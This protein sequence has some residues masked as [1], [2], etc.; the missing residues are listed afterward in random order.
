MTQCSFLKR[1]KYAAVSAS[2]ALGPIAVWFIRNYLINKTLTGSRNSSGLPVIWNVWRCMST[3]SDW[4]I[5]NM[6][7]SDLMKFPVLMNI[8]SGMVIMLMFFRLKQINTSQYSAKRLLAAYG[9]IAIWFV[10]LL[11]NLALHFVPHFVPPF[12]N[13]P[14]SVNSA[15]GITIIALFFWLRAGHTAPPFAKELLATYIYIFLYVAFLIRAASTTGFDQINTRLL[16]PVYVFLVYAILAAGDRLAAQVCRKQ[17]KYVWAVFTVLAVWFIY[18]PCHMSLSGLAQQYTSG[19]IFSNKTLKQSPLLEWLRHNPLEG[20]IYCNVPW[21]LYINTGVNSY[22]ST[23]K[24][25]N[26]KVFQTSF[27]PPKATYLI[28]YTK[29]PE[30]PTPYTPDALL[31]EL[32]LEVVK[33]FPDGAVL[34]MRH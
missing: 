34:R 18:W 5:P 13:I 1:F 28:W 11:K 29:N 14:M 8:V 22:E 16:C 12:I 27:S 23:D 2:I 24:P 33:K 30:R 10:F 15:L 9:L 17:K 7:P 26:L 6:P 31:A 25:H 19:T 20:T 4:F 3:L 32:P 21:L